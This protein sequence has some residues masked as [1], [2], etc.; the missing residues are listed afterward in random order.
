MIPNTVFSRMYFSY[1]TDH[2]SIIRI[3]IFYH[4]EFFYYKAH[5]IYNQ[6]FQAF[7]ILQIL[8]KAEKHESV[9]TLYKSDYATKDAYMQVP[10]DMMPWYT[11]IVKQFEKYTA[12]ISVCS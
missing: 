9:Q 7:S 1:I 3:S 10:N 4:E 11:S 5:L 2:N 8:L 6:Y 12:G